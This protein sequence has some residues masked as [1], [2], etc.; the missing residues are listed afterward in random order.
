MRTKLVIGILVLALV[1]TSIGVVSARGY[2]GASASD[3]ASAPAAG[4]PCWMDQLTEEER[5]EMHQQMHEFRQQIREQYNLTCP[6]GPQFVDEDGDGICDHKG[7]Y[8][9][10]YQRGHGFRWLA[11]EPIP[12]V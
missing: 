10:G 5:Q 12:E 9:Q 11:E 8:G 3:S 4:G 2:F 1:A 6:M 7:D